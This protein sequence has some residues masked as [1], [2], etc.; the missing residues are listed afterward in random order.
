MPSY[1]P[2]FKTI[3]RS[4]VLR[5]YETSQEKF[6]PTAQC[7]AILEEWPIERIAELPEKCG[8]SVARLVALLSITR[9]GFER[10]AAGDYTPTAALCLRMQKLEDSVSSGELKTKDELAPR[11]NEMRRRMT[12]FRQW[13]LNRGPGDE[14]PT[15]SISIKV[16][17]GKRINERLVLP[18]DCMPKLRVR[19]WQ[20]L[21]DVA[22]TIIVAVRKLARFNQRLLWT[23]MDQDYWKRY[24]NDTLPDVVEKREADR[25]KR[26]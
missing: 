23:Q 16:T 21:V 22:Q 26:N 4:G 8:I 2:R 7:K 5:T 14:L 13:W 17:W 9:A 19:D 20:T 11:R 3:H 1:V 6:I 25:G 24:A 10:I 15:I 12:L 18:E